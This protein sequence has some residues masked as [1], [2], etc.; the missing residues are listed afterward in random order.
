[1][2]A[3]KIR[4]A[5]IPY[6]RKDIVEL[7]IADGRLLAA[8][9][10]K[11]RAFCDIL[12][13]YYH[14]QFHK[15]LEHLKD[16]FVPFNPDSETK[17]PY[18]LPPAQKAEM[19]TKLVTAFR[20]V[21][22]RANYIPLSQEDLEQ[23]FEE[24][25]LIELRT[26]VDFDD[27]D[28]MICYYRGDSFRMTPV[29]HLFILKKEIR[30]DIFER[31]VLLLKFK[32]KAHFVA[33]ET[34]VEEMN[35]EPGKMYIYFYK[36]IP[37]HDLEFLFPNI[38]ASMTWKDLLLFG[39]PAVGAA[40]PVIVKALPQILLIVGV[41]AFFIFGPSVTFSASE[42]EVRNITPVLLALLSLV[43]ALGGFAFKQYNSYKN[44]QIKLQKHVTDTLFFRNLDN[45]AGVFHAL[46]DAAEEEECKEIILA[47]Y[48]L[49]THDRPLTPQQLD[50]QIE[51]WMAEKFG[52]IINFDINGPLHNLEAIQAPI[53]EEN[54]RKVSL[55]QRDAHGACHVLPL[56]KA[57]RVIDHIWDD[58]FLYANE[59]VPVVPII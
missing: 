51:T 57:Q 55:L 3:E 49:L 19:E 27:F 47:Y 24:E 53:K 17:P 22:E 11:F 45:N 59:Q 12:S 56:D 39:V 5:F 10:P 23:A 50:K 44:K 26:S 31:V 36:N 28:E 13:A 25:T 41:I 9:V 4:E 33:K 2:S 6:R 37:K 34:D 35:V 20:S 16:N 42:E 29:K 7:C 1:M 54:G 15:D 32:E 30:V 43:V 38:E 40:V 52:T 46:I 18:P 21:L 58:A 14:F 8:D 48:H